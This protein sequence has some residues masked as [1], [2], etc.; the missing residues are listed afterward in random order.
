MALDHVVPE[1][2]DWKHTDEGPECVLS[3]WLDPS[4]AFFVY[5]VIRESL[6]CSA[7]PWRLELTDQSVS[8]TKA[9]LVG[10]SVSVPITN[11]QLNLGT[12]QGW[13]LVLSNCVFVLMSALWGRYLPHRV[14]SCCTHQTCCCHHLVRFPPAWITT[15]TDCVQ[16]RS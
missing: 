2:L 7:R 8:H 9:S 11:G 10:S 12:W 1:S 16:G 4:D 14:P 15:L 3:L 5:L 6:G 13:S